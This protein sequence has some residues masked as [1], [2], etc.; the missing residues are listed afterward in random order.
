MATSAVCPNP[1]CLFFVCDCSTGLRFLVDTGAEVSVVPPSRTDWNHRQE[2]FSLQAVNNTIIVTYGIHSLSLDLSKFPAMTQAVSSNRPVKHSV[3]HHIKT[4][5]PP[6]SL[7]TRQ[8]APERLNIAQKKFDHML[9][10]GII[11]PSSSSWSS[12]LHMVPK[13][14]PGDWRPRPCGDYR[15][16]NRIL[17]TLD[18]CLSF[19]P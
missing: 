8:L 14:T 2:N 18:F 11:C 7:H 5:S 10:L 1:S 16:L 3:T 17:C 15:S 13:K 4:T 12:P 9:E 19:L 6:V